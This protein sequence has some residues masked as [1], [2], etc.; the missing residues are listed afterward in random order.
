[1]KKIIVLLTFALSFSSMAFGN[2][3]PLN[4]VRYVG[5][6]NVTTSKALNVILK[7]KDNKIVSYATIE[8][9]FKT[10]IHLTATEL[11]AQ[12]L[13]I[14]YDRHNDTNYGYLID[15]T[16]KITEPGSVT[17]WT[18]GNDSDNYQVEMNDDVISCFDI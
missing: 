1:M 14:E 4:I 15:Q 7:L 17:A 16:K 11:K 13:W 9:L 12:E 2:K 5:C 3:K 8:T 6:Q 10:D 18:S